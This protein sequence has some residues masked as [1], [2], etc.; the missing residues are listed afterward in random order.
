MAHGGEP[1]RDRVPRYYWSV[2]QHPFL[3]APGPIAIAHRGGAAE[4]VENTLEA[5]QSSHEL[6]YR[7]LETDAQLTGDGVVVAF[8]DARIDRV[9]AAS[10]RISEWRWAD[11]QKVRLH[12]SGRL[13]SVEDLLRSF[14]EARFNL[15]AKS[16][17]V[18][19]PLL[20]VVDAARAFD[21]VCIGSFS[22]RR[23]ALAR[24]LY[25]D[26]LCTSLGPR[27]I[28]DLMA[29]SHGIRRRTGDGLAVPAPAVFRGIPVISR[30]FV[31]QAHEEGLAVHAW[32]IDDPSE[33]RRLFDLGVDGIMTDQPTVL[34]QV[35]EERGTW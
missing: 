32:T 23:L 35:M 4:A 19:L 21:R 22:D 1:W 20:A 29:R 10:G 11:L 14:P 30:R 24:S 9:S 18:L 12:G 2:A 6:G 31:E 25:G 7:Y 27:A 3:D 17:E 15:D 5:F 16:N 8:H 33:M 13:S 34:R 28:L 26:R